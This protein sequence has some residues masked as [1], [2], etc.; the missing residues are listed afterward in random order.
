MTDIAWLDGRAEAFAGFDVES[1]GVNVEEDRIVTATF[2]AYGCEPLDLLIN[3]GIPIP[4]ETSAIHGITDDIAQDGFDPPEA[5][6]RIHG[7]IQDLWDDEKP[8]I[9]HNICFDLSMLDRELR[10]HLG[11]GLTVNGP[12]IDSM[13]LDIAADPDRPYREGSRK[14]PDVARCWGVQVVEEELHTSRGDVLLAVR[15]AFA[16]LRNGQ[17]PYNAHGKVPLAQLGLRDLH[18]L[19]VMAYEKQREQFHAKLRGQGR[20]PDDENVVWPVKP[21]GEAS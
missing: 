8:L 16:I 7:A 14:L 11:F 10:R 3:P 21:Y 15:A 2:H 19:Q 1:S 6:R 12:V 20:V 17:A 18:W 9:G 13:V 5:L 4:P